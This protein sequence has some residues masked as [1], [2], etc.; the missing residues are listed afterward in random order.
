MM[1][2]W[3]NKKK[4]KYGN[5]KVEYDGLTFDSKKEAIRW[6]EL[7]LLEKSG[8]IVDLQRQQKFV[9]IPAQYERVETGEFYKSGV[10]KGL[11]KTKEVCVEKAVNYIADFVYKEKGHIVVEDV[12]SD[13]TKTKEYVIKRKLMLKNFGIKIKEV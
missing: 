4:S 11:P 13:V 6:A 10:N 2:K 8:H 1:N 12:K 3:F 9:L 5:K 7:K